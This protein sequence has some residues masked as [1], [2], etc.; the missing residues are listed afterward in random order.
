MKS[1]FLGIGIF[2][3]LLV[4]VSCNKNDGYS[5]G[6]FQVDIATVKKVGT[7]NS[8]SL[9]LDNGKSLWIAA[10]DVWYKPVDNQ[11]VFVN[12]TLLSGE[13][14]G[15]DHFVKVN[16]IWNILTKGVIDLTTE[17]ADSIGHDPINI[18][19][20]WVGSDF[21][22]IDFMFNYGGVRPHAINL[23]KNL[24]D[25]DDNAD[26]IELEFRHNSY[27][28]Q[29]NRLLEG[30]ASF[31]LKPLQRNDVDLVKIK[32]KVKTWDGQKTYD[33]VYKY[34]NEAINATHYE[35][36]VL[37]VSSDEYY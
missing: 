37:V 29:S 20:V 18:N 34:N 31:N 36:P 1:K 19:A 10:S 12:Y 23:V 5:L 30:L 7:D 22:N 2:L 25:F 4:A 28:S 33:V 3:F 21:L 26:T 35:T 27:N 9:I 15:Y 6:K 24:S 11:R 17:N 32:V 16:A 8:Y 13:I 14:D